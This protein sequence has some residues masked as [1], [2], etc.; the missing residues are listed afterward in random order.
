MWLG[1]TAA[2]DC[3]A[4]Y[5]SSATIIRN[6]G[7]RLLQRI[8]HCRA[9]QSHARLCLGEG[10]WKYASIIDFAV[11][12]SNE[13]RIGFGRKLVVE[14]AAGTP[15]IQR[16]SRNFRNNAVRETDRSSEHGQSVIY[17]KGGGDPN[18]VVSFAVTR[19]RVW[20]KST[21]WTTS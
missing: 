5:P 7:K 3:R 2:G 8:H 16:P 17:C 6:Q 18:R 20:S 12:L 1:D 21:L 10:A 15:F 13:V 11:W 14:I 19:W 9:G 4:I